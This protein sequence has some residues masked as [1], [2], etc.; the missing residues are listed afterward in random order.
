MQSHSPSQLHISLYESHVSYSLCC[1]LVTRLYAVLYTGYSFSDSSSLHCKQRSVS[2]ARLN[3]G[4]RV[5]PI[6]APSVWNELQTTLK[7]LASL[8]SVRKNLKT[9]RPHFRFL[10]TTFART[11]F[12]IIVHDSGSM[13]FWAKPLM[14]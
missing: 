14:I 4:K 12:L 6:A 13:C 3:L 7:S 11:F 1:I 8:S 9:Y 5:F 10:M 2:T